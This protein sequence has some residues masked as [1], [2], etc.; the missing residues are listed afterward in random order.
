VALAT[1]TPNQATM[2]VTRALDN[3]TVTTPG[4]G[5]GTTAITAEVT[6]RG[7]TSG[8]SAT[9]EVSAAGSGQVL[10]QHRDHAGHR[11]H[12]HPD[13]HGQRPAPGEPVIVVARGGSQQ[14]RATLGADSGRPVITCGPA[15]PG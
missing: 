6:F 13:G 9:V 8:Q 12:D 3:V 1:A 4:S 11:R 14:C 15:S 2:A 5:T 10:A 7:L